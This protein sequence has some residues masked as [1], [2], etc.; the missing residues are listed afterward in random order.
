MINV[1]IILNPTL[2][3]IYSKVNLQIN[4]EYVMFNISYLGK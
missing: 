1:V 4:S 3:M 2:M